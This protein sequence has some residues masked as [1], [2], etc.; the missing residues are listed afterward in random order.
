MLESL[1]LIQE[2]LFEIAGKESI[3]IEI[4]IGR[5]PCKEI[6]Y[7]GVDTDYIDD[8]NAYIREE[9][10]W[11]RYFHQVGDAETVKFLCEHIDEIIEKFKVEKAKI[12]YENGALERANQKCVSAL[13]MRRIG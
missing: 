1:K 5:W 11:R 6:I 3:T 4:G 13:K 7:I 9:N 2:E 10:C 12:D 8:R